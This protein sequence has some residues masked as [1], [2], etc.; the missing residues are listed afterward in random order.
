M[1]HLS[2]TGLVLVK[3]GHAAHLSKIDPDDTGKYKTE[4][5]TLERLNHLRDT[6]SKLQQRLYAEGQRSLLIILQAIDTGGKDGAA[7]HLLTGLNPSGVQINSFKQPSA[8]ELSHD[9]LWRVH[10]VVPPRGII[11]LWNRSHYEDVLVARVHKTI[12]KEVWQRRYVDINN[13]ERV[14][15]DNGTQ[16]VKLFLHISKDEQKQRLQ[17][18]LDDPEKRWKFSP[19]DLKE[20]Q[21]WDDY[22]KAY[23]D[24]LTDCSTEVAPWHVVPANHK[25]AR[26][27]AVAEAVVGVLK[28]M[29]PKFPKINYDPGE[30]VIE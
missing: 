4:A 28:E 15:I 3:P 30:M 2:K 24:M 5:E 16:I 25:W 7:R 20:R 21:L 29:D 26:N 8:I 19:G 18:R 14:L 22:Q 17:D 13:F 12:P 11:G 27:I 23:E 1:S 10:Q 6:L 9:F